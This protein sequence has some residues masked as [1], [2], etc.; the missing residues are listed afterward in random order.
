LRGDY[1][2]LRR[3]PASKKAIEDCCKAAIMIAFLG[4]LL[5]GILIAVAV[6]A[7]TVALAASGA[8]G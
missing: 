2:R 6:R 8:A 7:G 1:R 3:P 4:L 5:T